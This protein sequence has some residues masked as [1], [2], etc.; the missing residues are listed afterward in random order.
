MSRSVSKALEMTGGAEVTETAK[1]VA[2]MDKFLDSVNVTSFSAGKRQRKPFQDPYQSA[3]D[4]RL[5]VCTPASNLSV[6]V[7]MS[8]PGHF[9]LHGDGPNLCPSLT[10]PLVVEGGISDVLG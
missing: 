1:F 5:K 6:H 7:G 4:F 8:R 2:M 10:H 9:C 3:S